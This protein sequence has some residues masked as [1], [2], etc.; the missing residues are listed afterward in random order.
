MD[1]KIY[2]TS[3]IEITLKVIGGRWKPLVLRYLRDEGEKRYSEILK[4]LGN[5]PKKTLTAQLR[6]LEAD[7]IVERRVTPTVP[8]QVSYTIT[9]HGKTLYPILKA[10]C[11][12]GNANVGGRYVMTHPTCDC[13][14]GKLKEK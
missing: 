8:V 14:K 2:V 3:E 10:M 6:E 9:E 12:W 7:G 4:Y 11:D 1:E 13:E 5:A